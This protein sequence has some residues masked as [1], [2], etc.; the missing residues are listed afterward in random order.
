MRRPERRIDDTA[1]IGDQAH[2]QVVQAKI[3]RDLFVAAPCDEGG[4][5]VDER[6]IAVHRHASCHADD[7]LLGD[8]FHVM[9][10]GHRGF[11]LAQQAGAEIGPDENDPLVLLRE[12]V[13]HVDAGFSQRRPPTLA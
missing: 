9:A 3:E 6:R 2:R 10:V 7:I 12:L 4:D 1:A 13:D 11:H 5:G 8:A